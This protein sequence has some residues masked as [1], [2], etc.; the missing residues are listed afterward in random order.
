VSLEAVA[1]G[2]RVLV[3][4]S[5]G[6][7]SSVA[8]ALLVARGYEV[9]G[10]TLHLWDYPDDGSVR[11]RCCAPEDLYDARRVADHLGIRHYT[12]DR[13]AE[14]RAA[15][16]D[17]FIESYLQGQTPS[18]CTNCNRSVKVPE[19]LTLAD[20][21]GAQFVATGHYARIDRSVQPAQLLR[22]HDRQKDQSYFLHAVTPSALERLLFP[23]G[24]LSKEAVRRTAL[25]IALPGADKG[26]SQELCFVPSGRYDAFIAAQ[27]GDRL[28]PGP[29]VDAQGTTLGEHGGV[30]LFTVGQRRNLGV[31]AGKRL[32]VVGI[33]RDAGA[34]RLGSPDELWANGAILESA[35]LAPDVAL[36]VTCDAV[37]RYRGA[38]VRAVVS[39]AAS[40]LRV[41]FATPV[42]AVVPG[43]VAVFFEGERV[44]GGGRIVAAQTEAPV[45]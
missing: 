38:A 29:L 3:A 12:F 33:D 7:D 10:V 25:E 19:L 11:S 17:P 36:P 37:V 4:M 41:D 18:P 9:I 31:A 40:G 43:Q 42:R 1:P 5:G 21:L 34:V 32:Y 30:H 15:V 45:S 16:V 44:L 35:A 23:L 26:E 8:A 39:A 14:F 6:V 24:E 13:R 22:A 27:A 2:A 20:D 28:R